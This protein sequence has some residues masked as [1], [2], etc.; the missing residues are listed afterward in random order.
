MI[1][2]SEKFLNQIEKERLDLT[3]LKNDFNDLES[4][5]EIYELLKG[6]LD[7]LQE[8][9]ESMDE[10]GYTAPFRSLNRYGSRVSEDVD[11]EELGEISRHNQIF[12]NKASAKKNSFDRVKY[13]ISAHRIALGNLE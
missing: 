9:K 4:F 8:M 12:R 13:A 11:F 6:N 2:E 10:S 3:N 7:K 1:T 5:L